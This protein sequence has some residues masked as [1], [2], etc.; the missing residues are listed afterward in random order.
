MRK[1]V[2]TLIELLVVIA[3]IAILASMLLPALN[4]ARERGR[5]IKCASNMRQMGTGMAMYSDSY[6]DYITPQAEGGFMWTWDHQISKFMGVPNGVQPDKVN[7]ETPLF[8]CDSD[9]EPRENVAKNPRS[10][11][12]SRAK[13][14]LPANRGGKWLNSDGK[15]VDVSEQGMLVGAKVTWVRSPSHV[16]L[17]AERIQFNNYI[18]NNACSGVM[19]PR[20]QRD[21]GNLPISHGQRWNYLFVDGHVEALSEKES[22]EGS[23]NTAS[24]SAIGRWKDTY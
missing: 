5:M 11:A 17:I 20:G 10:Y 24:D 18:A 16:I 23:D 6:G 14:A 8:K 4:Q 21:N 22:V 7:G 12:I 15:V 2:F 9:M 3:I 13:Y 19:H 1:N